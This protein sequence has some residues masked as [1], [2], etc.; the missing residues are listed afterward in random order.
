MDRPINVL[1]EA[2]LRL[3]S[4]FR[5]CKDSTVGCVGL[6]IDIFHRGIKALAAAFRP[7]GKE[8]GPGSGYGE[9]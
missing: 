9:L 2:Q 8:N 6:L 4:L 3:V 1:E 5:V 7:S